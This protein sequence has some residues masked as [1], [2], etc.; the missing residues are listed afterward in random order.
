[1]GVVCVF[2]ERFAFPFVRCLVVLL[3]QNLFIVEAQTESS[4]PMIRVNLV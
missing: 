2:L 4:W 1:M 3:T